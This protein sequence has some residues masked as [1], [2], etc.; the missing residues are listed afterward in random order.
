MVCMEIRN[1]VYNDS[2]YLDLYYDLD[3]REAV[4]DW[5]VLLINNI[6]PH[7]DGIRG[8]SPLWVSLSFF[9]KQLC[10]GLGWF[11]LIK[12]PLTWHSDF[13]W[14]TWHVIY[15]TTW[16][17]DSIINRNDYLLI[18]MGNQF[19]LIRFLFIELII[20]FCFMVLH[21]LHSYDVIWNYNSRWTWQGI[22]V[23]SVL[24]VCKV[25]NCRRVRGNAFGGHS[26][27]S[28]KLYVGD[29]SF[30]RQ[31]NCLIFK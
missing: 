1:W 22:V 19:D 6:D 27:K 21:R 7:V 28:V 2:I 17:F 4:G 16:W 25:W 13:L 3:G 24:G 15:K 23:G 12:H 8:R 5:F 20:W 11:Y 26:G 14:I 31:L 10:A 30:I 9:I 18:F 29:F